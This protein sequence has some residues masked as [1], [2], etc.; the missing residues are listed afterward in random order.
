MP[1]QPT[2]IH[3]VTV[4]F[5]ATDKLVLEARAEAAGQALDEYIRERVLSESDC[6]ER[7]L[8]LLADQIAQIADKVK[9]SL[10]GEPGQEDPRESSEERRARVAKQVRDEFS[11]IDLAALS[12]LFKNR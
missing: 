10:V 12:R 9:S 8:G 5:S 11:Q 3:P 7:V 6:E 2:T 4:N 1:T